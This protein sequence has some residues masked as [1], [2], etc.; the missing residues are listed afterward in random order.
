MKTPKPSRG[1]KGSIKKSV[2][3]EDEQQMRSCYRCT[4]RNRRKKMRP[5]RSQSESEGIVQS[6]NSRQ[7]EQPKKRGNLL[8]QRKKSG[9]EQAR[10]T[11]DFS[12]FVRCRGHE[13]MERER[14]RA[15]EQG[16]RWEPPVRE[17]GKRR[18]KSKIGE[19]AAE[20]FFFS[21]RAG[22]ALSRE[23]RRGRIRSAACTAVGAPSIAQRRAA[24]TAAGAPS[25]AQRRAAVP[26]GRQRP[27]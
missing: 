18:N 12:P 19:G 8:I 23:E 2:N 5:P 4:E 24:C 27:G 6:G 1:K 7:A 20:E 10:T 17:E 22:T 3:G 14:D 13:S 11:K 26:H 9:T 21:P 15:R 25:I 16:D